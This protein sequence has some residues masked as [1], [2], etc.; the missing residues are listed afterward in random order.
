LDRLTFT[1]T[2]FS[3]V[4]FGNISRLSI[5]DIGIVSRN[6]G[7]S[8]ASYPNTFIIGNSSSSINISTTFSLPVSWGQEGIIIA[9]S[10]T[11]SMTASNFPISGGV[12]TNNSNI[13]V[14]SSLDNIPTSGNYNVILGGQSKIT[15]GSF[16]VGVGNGVNNST[17]TLGD[18]TIGN[19][20]TAIGGGA[21]SK[22]TTGHNNTAIGGQA[23]GR[24]SQS[25]EDNVS[26]GNQSGQFAS[27]SNNI[28]IGTNA[29]RNFDGASGS[30]IYLSSHEFA[31]GFGI[32]GSPQLESTTSHYSTRYATWSGIPPSW[33]TSPNFG[34]VVLIGNE[35]SGGNS[36]SNLDN[37]GTYRSIFFGKGMWHLSRSLNTYIISTSLPTL[38]TWTSSN[39][40]PQPNNNAPGSSLE[41]VAGPGRGGGTAGD[42]YFS[43]GV[44][45]ASGNDL[46]NKVNRITIK[47]G[48]GFIGIGPGT[49]SNNPTNLLHIWGTSSGSIRIQDGSQASGRV[50][51]SDPDGVGTWQTLHT[52]LT[53]GANRF[54]PV[55]T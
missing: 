53:G 18:L 32:T 9:P 43:T 44:L 36:N 4:Q 55:L 21:L 14:V 34:N 17:S 13:L 16:N 29:G 12:H 22:I 10:S 54:L 24:S 2:T 25:I 37:I 52:G 30:V 33:A 40:S 42:L 38:Q 41:L 11:V 27:S 23:M 47:G 26:I 49:F 46:Q 15:T 3:N 39:N 1:G 5:E 7:T 6:V 28:F 45:T 48:S 35:S 31:N 51:T 8:S 19:A 50:L 20:N